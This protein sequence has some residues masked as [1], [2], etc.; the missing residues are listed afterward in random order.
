MDKYVTGNAIGIVAEPNNMEGFTD[1]LKY[2][3]SICGKGSTQKLSFSAKRTWGESQENMD[4]RNRGY[5]LLLINGGL[6]VYSGTTQLTNAFGS[7]AYSLYL[8]STLVQTGMTSSNRIYTGITL[9]NGIYTIKWG[10]VTGYITPFDTQFK[11]YGKPPGSGS[12]VT[13]TIEVLYYKDRQASAVVTNPTSGAIWAIGGYAMLI[14]VVAADPVYSLTNIYKD[15]GT[16][17]YP[18]GDPAAGSETAVTIISQA[19][20]YDNCTITVDVAIVEVLTYTEVSGQS[21]QVLSAV[22]QSSG[23][24]QV[25]IYDMAA[26]AAVIVAQTTAAAF[27]VSEDQVNSMLGSS[28]GALNFPEIGDAAIVGRMDSMLASV[29]PPSMDFGL[30]LPT[31]PGL[32]MLGLGGFG[33]MSESEARNQPSLMPPNIEAVIAKVGDVLATPPSQLLSQIGKGGIL[34]DVFIDFAWTQVENSGDSSAWMK[35]TFPNTFSSPPTVM[36]TCAF[37]SGWIDKLSWTAP[38][39]GMTPP[40]AN[41]IKKRFMLQNPITAE[42]WSQGEPING[43]YTH[44]AQRA[45][46]VKQYGVTFTNNQ[47]TALGGSTMPPASYV[48]NSGMWETEADW[49]NRQALLTAPTWAVNV[50]DLDA[51]RAQ[52]E[53]NI[54]GILTNEA[55]KQKGNN[56]SLVTKFRKAM[57][58]AMGNWQFELPIPGHPKVSLNGIRDLAVAAIAAMGIAI[59][60]VTNPILFTIVILIARWVIGHIYNVYK[61]INEVTQT[62]N[63]A[64]TQLAGYQSKINSALKGAISDAGAAAANYASQLQ[65]QAI[66]GVNTV[67]DTLTTQTQAAVNNVAANLFKGNDLPQMKLPIATVRNVTNTDC[68]IFVP[69]GATC[70]VWVIGK[71]GNPLGGFLPRAMMQLNQPGLRDQFEEWAERTRKQLP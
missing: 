32:G 59:L 50:P 48:A 42:Q 65:G 22:E 35:C 68:E 46:M 2:A 52:A 14:G 33:M 49:I 43:P 64:M 56:D 12:I 31:P 51:W 34:P 16:K 38:K 7:V 11:V 9:P 19:M 5:G 57:I 67:A 8:G 21:G 70:H 36:A 45:E 54:S 18:F 30:G 41:D 58:S 66:S 55:N 15:Y 53:S 71:V 63:N 13:T 29:S 23:R 25:R 17:M 44:N 27:G 61:R 39:L 60:A 37:R 20:E 10:S 6:P 24:R 62:L 26:A 4:N 28:L 40:S 1:S 47:W 3:N 69:K